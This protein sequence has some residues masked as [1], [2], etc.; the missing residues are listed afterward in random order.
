MYA[1]L[2]PDR[3]IAHRDVIIAVCSFLT[4]FA[5]RET[6]EIRKRDCKRYL[7]DKESPGK[8]ANLGKASVT[9]ESSPFKSTIKSARSI[10]LDTSKTFSNLDNEKTALENIKLNG[11]KYLRAIAATD[12][13]ESLV[14]VLADSVMDS[15][16]S[17]Y[18]VQAISALSLYAPLARKIGELGAMKDLVVVICNSENFRDP[19]VNICIDCI[20]NIL[21]QDDSSDQ[22]IIETLAREELIISL[23]WTLSKIIKEGYKLGDKKLRNELFILICYIVQTPKTHP[24]FLSREEND[25]NF[26]EEILRYSSHDELVLTAA[27]SSKSIS[28]RSSKAMWGTEPEDLEFK[29]L[30][31]TCVS[32]LISTQLPEALDIVINSD[33]IPA[34]LIY[35]D[36]TQKT[37]S[38][39]RW[40]EP[41]LKEIQ[42]HSLDVIYHTLP[43]IP[44][45]FQQQN[46]N[47]CLVNFLTSNNDP[48]HK[49]LTLKALEI[50]SRF[51]FFKVE[52]AEEGL[53][54]ILHDIIHSE[55]D[56]SLAIRELALAIISNTC[57][58]C[59]S[60]QKEI[61]RKGWIELIKVNIKMLPPT[62]L[63]EPDQFMLG[64]I[65]CLWN[66][67]LQNKRSM[68]HFIDIEGVGTLLDYLDDCPEVHRRLI[69]SCLCQLLKIPRAKTVFLHWNSHKTMSNASQLLIRIYE[70]EEK[71]LGV[72]YEQGGILKDPRRP[73]TYNESKGAKGFERLREALQAGE[74]SDIMLLRKK[75]LEFVRKRDLRASIYCVLS[76]VGFDSNEILPKEMQKMEVIRMYP[77]FRKGELLLD[78]KN[79]LESVGIKPINDD[80]EYLEY[81]LREAYD[82]ATNTIKNQ[83]MIARESKKEEDKQLDEFYKSILRV[84]AN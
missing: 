59:R 19:L 76:L 61:R 22:V 79:E 28:N 56:Y 12:L 71:R 48:E 81:C 37:L 43:L 30:L 75:Q 60:N 13:P 73:L 78:I 32:R 57:T 53:F 38:I 2:K 47:Y 5:T 51:S 29:R 33:F 42:R 4:D 77:E 24:Y 74:Q 41:Q 46:G 68:L 58:D 44:E 18:I 50:A 39:T 66:A 26:L 8:T 36:P 55:K 23:R 54:D 67:I 31:W 64:V 11:T 35:L 80:K 69:I 82:Q 65:D 25:E 9:K 17:A 49:Y 14:H 63:G 15:Q 16:L 84:K 52:L 6:L 3:G 40:Q 34:I 20:W 7:V 10:K 83:S 27:V 1:L 72:L 62:V 70:E 21:E 45:Y